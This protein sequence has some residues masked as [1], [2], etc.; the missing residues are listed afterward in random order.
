[1]MPDWKPAY[2]AG[3]WDGEGCIYFARRKDYKPSPRMVRHDLK[4][5]MADRSTIEAFFDFAVE[6][7][8][9]AKTVKLFEEKRKIRRRRPLWRVEICAKQSVYQVLFAM[10]PFMRT[11]RLEAELC[12]NY[13]SR[14]LLVGK[15]HYKVTPFDV[16][17]A[18]LATAMR[19]GCGEARAEAQE[20]L[21]QVIPS[22]AVP[23]IQLSFIGR[24]WDG[25]TEGVETTAPSP[26]SNEPHERP[27]PHPHTAE[28]ED[29]VRSSEETPSPDSNDQGLHH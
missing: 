1:M 17:L 25:R 9:D 23:G 13:L 27:A 5:A 6:I 10:V 8:G 7:V 29:I 24:G 18:D 28:G 11:K 22:Q 16:R 26:N 20:L 4:L 2:F 3:L 12:L 19:N 21:S 14:S 15:H